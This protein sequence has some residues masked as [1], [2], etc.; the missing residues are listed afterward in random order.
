MKWLKESNLYSCVINLALSTR[1]IYACFKE[2]V[3]YSAKIWVT[4]SWYYAFKIIFCQKFSCEI[5]PLSV[6]SIA[7]LY[8]QFSQPKPCFSAWYIW[9][10]FMFSTIM[11]EK[12]IYSYFNINPIGAYSVGVWGKLGLIVTSS[13]GVPPFLGARWRLDRAQF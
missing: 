9:P 11:C 4:I 3:V 10:N 8:L 12:K 2:N 1:E 7:W 5:V 6:R 13:A